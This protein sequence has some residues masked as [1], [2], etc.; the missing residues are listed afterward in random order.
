[1]AVKPRKLSKNL[2]YQSNLAGEGLG[3]VL[4]FI[5]YDSREVNSKID[6]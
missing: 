1:M 3:A 2:H 5:K 6:H 4:I